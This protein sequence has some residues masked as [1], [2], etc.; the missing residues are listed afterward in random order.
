MFS[1]SFAMLFAMSFAT[2]EVMVKI[3]CQLPLAM[4]KNLGLLLLS[5][6]VDVVRLTTDS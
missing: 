1:M 3:Q 2:L 4:R 5:C 6:C